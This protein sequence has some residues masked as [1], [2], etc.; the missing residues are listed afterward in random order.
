M[1]VA[2]MTSIKTAST[3]MLSVRGN[4]DHCSGTRRYFDKDGVAQVRVVF[5]SKVGKHIRLVGM[6]ADRTY[7]VFKKIGNRLEWVA[8]SLSLDDLPSLDNPVMPQEV[9]SI[10]GR[11][12]Y[13]L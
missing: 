7:S 1:T 6:H 4:P 5:V 12:I 2:E 11:E 3:L 9:D 10:I 8:Y 13:Q